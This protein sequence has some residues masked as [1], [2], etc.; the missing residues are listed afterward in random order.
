MRPAG[1]QKLGGPM[2]F[3]CGKPLDTLSVGKYARQTGAY[4]GPLQPRPELFHQ[5]DGQPFVKVD[6]QPKLFSREARSLAS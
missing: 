4:G 6:E 5:S 3:S 1:S 2:S